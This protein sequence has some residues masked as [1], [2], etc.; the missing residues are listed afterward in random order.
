MSPKRKVQGGQR[1]CA[2]S[3]LL[4]K[5]ATA[6]APEAEFSEGEVGADTPEPDNAEKSAGD[7][8]VEEN[9]EAGQ[10]MDMLLSCLLPNRA[11]TSC[12]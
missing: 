10:G 9:V 2:N 5:E 12:W 11:L 1:E 3:E 6:P 4:S 8:A 7:S